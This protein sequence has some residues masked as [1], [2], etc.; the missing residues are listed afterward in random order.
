MR[1]GGAAA[2]ASAAS[3]KQTVPPTT[4]PFR[5]T[6]A[7]DDSA[8]TPSILVP[9]LFFCSPAHPTRQTVSK[10]KNA[11]AAYRIQSQQIKELTEEYTKCVAQVEKLKQ[12]TEVKARAAEELRV[13]VERER[14]ERENHLADQN[15][16]N[17][18]HSAANQARIAAGD[19]LTRRVV[20]KDKALKAL[21]KAVMALDQ[22]EALVPSLNNTI[23]NLVKDK[24]GHTQNLVRLRKETEAIRVDIEARPGMPVAAQLQQLENTPCRASEPGR[25]SQ[26]P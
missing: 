6:D 11:E 12:Q 16:L 25:S 24:S 20:E 10:L 2:Q 23:D 9:L 22:S 13:A 14:Q 17:L 3:L 21:K 5:P 8:I 15:H 18:E 19:E 7:F 1:L 4:W 26:A